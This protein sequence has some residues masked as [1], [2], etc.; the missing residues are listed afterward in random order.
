M[1]VLGIWGV[2]AVL[3]LAS[4]SR[5]A[6]EVRVVLGQPDAILPGSFTQV[7]NVV[8]LRDGRVALAD[9]KER[10]F[11]FADFGAGVQTIGVQTDTLL[12]G[13]PAP[14]K[15]KIPGH[16]LRFR[17]DTLALVDYAIE[18][19]TLW[20]ERGQFL[21]ILRSWAVAGTNQPLVYDTLGYAY[22]ADYRSIL[23]GIEPGR[24]YV[25]DSAPVLRYPREDTTADTIAQ[26]KLPEIGQGKF[27]EEIRQ[28]A[29]VF[30]PNDLFGVAPDG[31]LWVAR[32]TTNSVDWRAADGSWTR[33]KPVPF[34][35]IRV[36][37][38]DK[39][40]FMDAA[41][42][43][44]L[45]TAL[46]IRYPFADYKSPFSLA[47]TGADHEVWL[48]RARVADDSVPV[49]DVLTRDGRRAR[50]VQLPPGA[51]I[52]GF[53]EQGRIY[54]VVRGADGRQKVERYRLP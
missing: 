18:R 13:D 24:S 27:G 48:Q 22:K 47:L 17:G 33:G 52:S 36:T 4:C 34:D 16:V 3:G 15:Y 28:V 51:L 46:D 1:K 49:Y 39:D 7:S 25:V 42:R 14:G 54:L 12:P 31:A 19:T 32:A 43:S 30:S 6:K 2:I 53:G 37:D 21:A 8:E 11:I 35:R 9:I 40:R 29:V 5:P 26:L 20:N 44:G 38:A 50:T 10:K 41:H 45:P 23:G